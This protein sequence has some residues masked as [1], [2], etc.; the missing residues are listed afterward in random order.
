MFLK[1]HRRS[2]LEMTGQV[3]VPFQ[4][5]PQLAITRQLWMATLQTRVWTPDPKVAP[6]PTM[7]SPLAP[8]AYLMMLPIMNVWLLYVQTRVPT[9]QMLLNAFLCCTNNIECMC[10]KH[11]SIQLHAF[12]RCATSTSRNEPARRPWHW[13][14]CCTRRTYVIWRS[15]LLLSSKPRACRNSVSTRSA[16]SNMELFLTT[17]FAKNAQTEQISIW[18]WGLCGRTH[19]RRP[20]SSRGRLQQLKTS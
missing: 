20:Y 2:N 5:N 7:Q 9:G 3:W 1:Q 14:L 4:V 6:L 11:A 17:T 18:W 10:P 13:Q 19:N 12:S 15:T 8:N 16:M